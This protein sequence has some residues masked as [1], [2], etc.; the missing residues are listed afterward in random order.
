M[1]NGEQGLSGIVE[2]GHRRARAIV[3]ALITSLFGYAIVVEIIGAEPA[4]MA[5]AV[6]NVVRYVLY[7]VAIAMVFAANVT[8]ALMLRGFRPAGDGELV[9]RLTVAHVVAAA[10]AEVPA[11]LGLVLFA[12]G[13]QRVDFYF[14]ALISLYLL[15]RNFPRRGRWERLAARYAPGG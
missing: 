14:L 12:I 15:L 9:A 11:I 5:D 2:A 4:I 1:S 8:L 13:R 6:S 7:A 10:L 3:G